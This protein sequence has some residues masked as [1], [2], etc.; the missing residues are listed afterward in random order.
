[1]QEETELDKNWGRSYETAKYNQIIN[2]EAGKNIN[3]VEG[4]EGNAADNAVEAYQKSFK[5]RKDQEVTTI[6]K[7]Q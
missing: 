4:L 3:Q 2:P 7:L 1:L 6:L 5:Q